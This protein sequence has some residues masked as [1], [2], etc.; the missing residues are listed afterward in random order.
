MVLRGAPEK[1]L[2]ARVVIIFNSGRDSSERERLEKL[3]QNREQDDAKSHRRHKRK[4]T[5]LSL[6]RPAT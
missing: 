1:G 4:L 5:R 3:L 6:R 2:A